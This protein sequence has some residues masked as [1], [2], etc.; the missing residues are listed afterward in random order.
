MKIKVEIPVVSACQVSE[1]SYN[2]S[3]ACHA[4]A[5]TIG[6]GIKPGCDTFFRSNRHV[7]KSSEAGVG[8]CK[9]S[10]CIYNDDFECSA[11]GIEVGFAA[12]SINCLTFSPR[13]T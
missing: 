10:G 9:V 1:C 5:I 12:D 8:A 2:R 4:G 13:S 3:N 11:D 7:S 6:D